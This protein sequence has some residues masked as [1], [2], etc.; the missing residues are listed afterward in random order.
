VDV[1][2]VG[3]G[4]AE[5]SGGPVRVPEHAASRIITPA[6]TSSRTGRGARLARRGRALRACPLLTKR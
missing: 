4:E 1:G 3:E 2:P 5:A 6:T